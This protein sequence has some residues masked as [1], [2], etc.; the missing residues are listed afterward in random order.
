[1]AD[2]SG[3]QPRSD[4]KKPEVDHLVGVLEAKTGR[5]MTG[6]RRCHGD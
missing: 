4:E 6:N 2:R 3:K 1:M 5:F